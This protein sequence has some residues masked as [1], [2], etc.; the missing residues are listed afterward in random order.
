MDLPSFLDQAT[1]SPA[2][3]AVGLGALFVGLAALLGAAVTAPNADR[4]AVTRSLASIEALRKTP[5]SLR[6]R[7]LQRPLARRSLDP[8]LYA[9]TRLGARLTPQDQVAR[10]RRRLDLAGNP[11][12]W[13]VDRVVSLKVLISF[14]G[15][16]LT[17]LVCLV[18]DI[19]LLPSAVAVTVVGVTGW[20]T[21]SMVIYQLAYNRSQRILRDLPDAMDLMTISV[22]SGLSF[23]AALS[24]V[25]RNSEGPLAEEFFRVLQEMQ[26]GTG[27][28][29]AL[30]AVSER[31]DV[32]DL[33]S[34][35]SAMVQADSY[36]VPIASALRVQADEMRV[37]RSQR[38]EEAAQRVPVKIL[39]PL[40]FGILPTLFVV[41]IGPGVIR[42][43]YSFQGI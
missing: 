33:R 13:D 15:V 36:G 22:E 12:A 5:R 9:A 29:D 16:A 26:I 6:E 24:Q 34:F 27:R 3:L 41:I 25:A 40:I 39:F 11:S 17:A 23:D 37:R 2:W 10:I 19:D 21:P 8:V 31:T 14:T 35:V 4:A 42:A 20:F 28:M 43:F 1:A 38:A 18:A 7:E 32:L 30:R